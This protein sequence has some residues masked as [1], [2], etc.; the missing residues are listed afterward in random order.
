MIYLAPLQGFTDFVYRKA[1]SQI[2]QGIDKYF[3]PYILSKNDSVPRKYVQEIWP[4]N[5][6][7]ANV[8]PQ[9]LAKDGKE[10]LFL[11]DYLSGYGYQEINLNLGCPYPMVTKRGRGAGLLPFPEN[12]KRMLFE[13]YEKGNVSLSVKIRSGLEDPIEIKPVIQVLNQFP[14]SEIIVH[15][16]TASQLY[17]GK[18]IENAF[19]WTLKNTHLPLVYNGDI[20]SVDDF[21]K[22]K[23]KF[24]QIETWMLGR[25]ILKNLFLPHEIKGEFVKKTLKYEKLENFHEHVYEGYAAQLDNAGNVLNKMKQFW[26][27]FSHHFENQ[28]KIQKRIKK[29]RSL[30]VYTAEVQSIFAGTDLI[31]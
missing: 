30:K 20:F 14:L 2:F 31:E 7:S 4:E 18:V 29:L 3:I 19:R 15:P 25:G 1:H 23:K 16:R 10:L 28:R 21:H 27:Y 6:P 5:N 26:K 11:S 12:I 13:Y 22:K 24:G 9:V 17:K 8:I